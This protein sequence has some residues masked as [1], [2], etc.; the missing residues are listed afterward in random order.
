MKSE[1]GAVFT[2]VAAS[3]CCLGPV[4]FTAI[5]SGALAAAST[6]LA[7]VRP[8]FLGLTLVLLGIGFYRTYR[9]P[10][11]R[12]ALF[13]GVCAPDINR[14]A[15]VVLWTAALVVMLLAA[16]PYYAEYLF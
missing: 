8:M 1:I 7:A 4:V 15:R 12:V 6:R 5:G 3:A 11:E 16:F 13:D 10:K 2:A 9:A 14:K